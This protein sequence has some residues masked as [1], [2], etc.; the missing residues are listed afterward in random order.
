M[1]DRETRKA[2]VEHVLRTEAC[3]ERRRWA[4]RELGKIW[5][6]EAAKEMRKEIER[7]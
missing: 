4:A 2:Y 7:L 5:A 1:I 6:E 3:P